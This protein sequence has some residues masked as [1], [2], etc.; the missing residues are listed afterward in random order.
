MPTPQKEPGHILVHYPFTDTALVNLARGKPTDQSS[1]LGHAYSSLAVDGMWESDMW[2]SNTNSFTCAHTKSDNEKMWWMVNLEHIYVVSKVVILNRIDCCWE[3]LRDLTITVG[4]TESN[5]LLCATYEGAGELVNITCQTSLSGQFVR[6]NKPGPDAL[7]LCEVGVYFTGR[8]TLVTGRSVE[9]WCDMTNGGWA[10]VQ[11]RQDGTE[12]FYRIW[13]DYVKGFGDRT[14]EYWFGLENTFGLTKVQSSLRIEIEAFGDILPTTAY[15]LYDTFW[16]DDETSNFKLHVSN[17]SGDCGDSFTV[18]DGY[19]FTTIDRDN[20]VDENMNCAVQYGGAWWHNECHH[21]STTTCHCS[22]STDGIA[23]AV[24]GDNTGTTYG[25]RKTVVFTSSLQTKDQRFK[26]IHKQPEA[27][28]CLALYTK[29]I[30]ETVHMLS[31]RRA[32]LRLRRGV[33]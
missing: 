1:T 27:I 30:S 10:V 12:N 14:G 26:R 7:Q 24:S 11:R 3:R 9:T 16:M 17:F 2:F 8:S 4:E 29:D 15:G 19:F 33:I 21:K 31:S 6:I 20:D 28:D 25:L 5:M 32:G 13:Q 18:Q 23:E 22:S